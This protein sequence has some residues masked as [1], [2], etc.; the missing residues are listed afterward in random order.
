VL[1]DVAQ[2][3]YRNVFIGLVCALA[4]WTC[5]AGPCPQ[6][7]AAAE[8]QSPDTDA[9][10]S[11]PR[12]NAPP[13]HL[14]TY[15]H[16]GLVLWGW[17]HFRERLRN[18]V[19]WLDRYPSFK[20]GLDNEAYTYDALAEEHPEVLDQLRAYLKRYKG[21]FGIGTCT[22]G[23]PLSVFINEESNIRQIEYALE[24]DRRHFGTAPKVY[25]MSEHAMHS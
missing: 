18:A 8:T 6:R 19:E 7:V 22:Y 5:A 13:L 2:Q 11:D 9:P 25:L 17:E 10:S 1:V 16:G 24:A 20:I 3:R 14:L 15:D 12:G 4:V 21:R 23:Q